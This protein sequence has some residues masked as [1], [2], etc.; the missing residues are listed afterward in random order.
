VQSYLEI[1]ENK[2]GRRACPRCLGKAEAATLA[3]LFFPRNFL[4]GTSVIYSAVILKAGYLN[5]G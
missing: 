3:D 2:S 1:G 4:P 5:Y